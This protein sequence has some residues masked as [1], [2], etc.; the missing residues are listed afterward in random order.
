MSSS[1]SSANCVSDSAATTCRSNISHAANSAAIFRMPKAHL[2][3]VRPGLAL[4]GYWGG[5]DGERPTD[6]IPTMR[7][8]SRLVAIRRIPKDQTVGYGRTFRAAR[9]SVIG[10][11]PIGYAD[12]YRRSLSNRA[13]MTLEAARGLPRR[14]VPVLDASAWIRPPWT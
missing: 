5:P 8:V 7:V 12:G 1:P 4:Y 13:V 11:V 14:I 2:D 6:L 10:L 3:R 9:D